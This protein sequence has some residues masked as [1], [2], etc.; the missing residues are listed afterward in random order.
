MTTHRTGTPEEHLQAR[1]ELL[2]AEKELT[3][4]GDEVAR[5][6]R[7]LPWVPVEKTY[8]FDTDDGE[9]TLPEL[10]AGRS[11][12]LVYHFMFGP[13]WTEG[14]P[15][16]SYWADNF[17]GG[18]VHLN[19]RDVTMVCASRAPLARIDAYR[20]RMG[21]SFPWV[22]SGR[23]DFNFDYAVS[24]RD[25]PAGA[26]QREMPRGVGPQANGARY[27]F[28]KDPFAPEMPGLSAFALDDGVVYHTYS[29]YSRGLDAF[30]G[31]YQ[32]LDRAP[33]GR[34]EDRGRGP[35]FWIRRRDEYEP[36]AAAGA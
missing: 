6:R 21:W 1:L 31:V 28:T 24:L 8:V 3:R 20:R 23:S 22:S 5:R 7:E 13:D 17:N 14:C 26:S 36:A 15:I 18:I 30:N 12:L 34:D 35:V 16:C 33:K 29:C 9:K 2:E 10:F 25:V 27:N 19:Q 4:R 11:Q 32:L